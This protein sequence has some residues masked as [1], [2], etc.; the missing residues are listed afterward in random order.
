MAIKHPQIYEVMQ[1]IGFK[2]NEGVEIYDE[3]IIEFYEGDM[4]VKGEVEWLQEDCRF[5]VRVS[6]EEEQHYLGL[7]G[8]E[9]LSCT[10]IGNMYESK[11]LLER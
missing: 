8:D 1:Y 5:V 6:S 4:L 7:S 9:K 11:G 10:V 3:D 2:D